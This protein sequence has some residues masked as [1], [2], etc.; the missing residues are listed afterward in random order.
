MVVVQL[1]ANVFTTRNSLTLKQN[2]LKIKKTA[3]NTHIGNRRAEVHLSGEMYKAELL[4]LDW[5]LVLKSPPI[6]NMPDVV[7]HPMRPS[8]ISKLSCSLTTL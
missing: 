1:E 6:A 2:E 5:A 7:C 3:A 8:S 4:F